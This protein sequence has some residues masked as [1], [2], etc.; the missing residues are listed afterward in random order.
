MKIL[1]DPTAGGGNGNGNAP[2]G[3]GDFVATLPE[4]IRPFVQAKGWK[5]PADIV[6]S[7]RESEKLLGVQRLPAPQ[8]TWKDE[9]WGNFFKAAGRPESPDK[10]GM[11]QVKLAEG[12][13]IDDKMM[14]E[15]KAEFHKMG[16]TDK[17]F[18]GV[19]GRYMNFLNT[20]VEQLARDREAKQAEASS[21]LKAEWKDN[22][23]ANLEIARS[24][25][26]EFGDDDVRAHLEETGWG[27]DPRLIKLF[28]TI[29][30]GMLD[31]SATGKGT[32][33]TV[34]NAAN[35]AAEIERLRSGQEPAFMAALFNAAD[36]AH[37]SAVSRWEQLHKEAHPNEKAAA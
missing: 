11:P 20:S 22:Y 15:V 27:N 1:L 10:Y 16:L 34:S 30:K 37:K 23:D 7:Y 32:G 17:Q 5:A 25:V 21:T 13:A 6:N 8:P 26:K 36:P 33:L 9:D 12:V 19:M 28:H 29:G 31:D 35:A 4:D 18:Q 3:N 24:V 14:G 2:N